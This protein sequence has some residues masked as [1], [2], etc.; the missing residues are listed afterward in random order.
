MTATVWS[1]AE[2]MLQDHQRRSLLR[3]LRVSINTAVWMVMWRDPAIQVQLGISNIY[4]VDFLAPIVSNADVP[5]C[6]PWWVSVVMKK[7][8]KNEY[9]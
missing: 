2:K 9:K 5:V 4:N 6:T 7:R 3:A 1:L 8:G